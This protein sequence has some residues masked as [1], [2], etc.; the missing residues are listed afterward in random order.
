KLELTGGTVSHEDPTLAISAGRSGV[1]HVAWNDEHGQVQ[2]AS[3]RVTCARRWASD[4]RVDRVAGG[5]GELRLAG[6]GWAGDLAAAARSARLDPAR[7]TPGSMA[8]ARESRRRA[9]RAHSRRRASRRVRAAAEAAWRRPADHA[10]ARRMD[11][12]GRSLLARRAARRRSVPAGLRLIGL[13]ELDPSAERVGADRSRT[14]RTAL[15]RTGRRATQ[16]LRAVER[17]A[18]DP[19]LHGTGIRSERT[20]FD[21][22]QDRACM[23]RRRTVPTDQSG[24]RP[25]GPRF[26]RRPRRALAVAQGTRPGADDGLARRAVPARRIRAEPAVR[27]R[28]VL[29]RSPAVRQRYART[30]PLRARPR[31][32]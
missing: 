20:G 17:S 16:P 21:R 5:V 10:A 4:D 8:A 9:A 25:S 27:N 11:R 32:T 31:D 3:G 19:T 22:R 24:H 26:R 2:T 28:Q 1:F 7:R 6:A 15:Q 18:L 30:A 29:G 14:R 23:V 12:G 13:G